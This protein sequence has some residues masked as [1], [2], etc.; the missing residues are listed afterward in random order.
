MVLTQS[1]SHI[2][3]MSMMSGDLAVKW[4]EW[5]IN[6]RISGVSSVSHIGIEEQIRCEITI[7]ATSWEDAMRQGRDQLD[8]YALYQIYNVDCVATSLVVIHEP[9]I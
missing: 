4:N 1:D 2:P 7:H 3:A 6:K 8:L 9:N 5:V